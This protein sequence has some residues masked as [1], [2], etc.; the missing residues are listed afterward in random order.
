ML[1]PEQTP[2]NSWRCTLMINLLG[3]TTFPTF[4]NYIS[5]SVGIF[6]GIRHSLNERALKSLYFSIV[7]S[8]L[9]YA[10]GAW[11]SV[12]KTSLRQLH[13]LHNK[14]IRAMTCNSFRSTLDPLYK[15]LNPAHVTRVDPN[16]SPFFFVNFIYLGK[17]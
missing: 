15:Y 1:Y 7:Y 16:P 9:Q 2:V 12:G 3:Q 5:R 6:Y 10:I 13:V 8:H 4:R 14:M 17:C 11:G